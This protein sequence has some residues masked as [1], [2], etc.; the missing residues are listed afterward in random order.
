MRVKCIRAP[1]TFAEMKFNTCLD[2]EAEELGIK[3]RAKRRPSN[4]PDAWDDV[5]RCR[6]KSWKSH[7]HTQY[8]YVD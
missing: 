6:E 8:K 2:P 5:P 3:I 7:R 1:R 4:L